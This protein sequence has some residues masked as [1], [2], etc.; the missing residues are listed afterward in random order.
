M[1]QLSDFHLLSIAAQNS[2]TQVCL[3][4]YKMSGNCFLVPEFVGLPCNFAPEAPTEDFHLACACN[5]SGRLCQKEAVTTS[6]VC[7]SSITFGLK[8]REKKILALESTF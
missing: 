8:E 2:R 5:A 7:V 6:V 4:S 3:M 1:N